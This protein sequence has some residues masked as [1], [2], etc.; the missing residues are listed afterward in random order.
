MLKQTLDE[1]SQS[2]CELGGDLHSLSHRLH[3]ST[4]DTLGLI[5][6]LKALCGEFGAKQGIEVDFAPEDIP[7]S[8]RPDVALCLFRIAQEGLQNL[9]KHSGTK[10]AQLSVRHMGDRL[11]LSLCDQGRGFDANKL[12]K[13]G[14]GILSMQ[15]RARLLGGE[16]EIHSKPGE[17]TQIEAWVPLLPVADPLNI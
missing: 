4:L 7:R 10:R 5:T 14:L 16:F 12:E 1:F 13:P 8:V 6:G 2:V 11:F 3:S 17:G 9:K 15:G